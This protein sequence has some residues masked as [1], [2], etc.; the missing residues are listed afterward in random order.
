M[1]PDQAEQI[2]I[3][4]ESGFSIVAVFAADAVAR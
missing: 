2:R 1:T 3:A 4:F